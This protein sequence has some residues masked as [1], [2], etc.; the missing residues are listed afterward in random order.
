MRLAR[1]ASLCV[2]ILVVAGLRAGGGEKR[3]RREAEIAMSGS[4]RYPSWTI[5][6]YGVTPEKA[7]EVALNK[8][9]DQ[10]RHYLAHLD[11]PVQ[12]RP[13]GK[14]ID[15]NLVKTRTAPKQVASDD[16][17]LDKAFERTLQIEVGPKQYR[18]IVE[19]DRQE[20]MEQRQL[21]LARILAG[22]VALLVAAVGYLRL[23][24]ATKGY[25]TLWLRLAALGLVGAVGA[26]LVLA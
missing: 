19:Y 20:C 2:L 10:V 9:S 22:V 23:D 24:E 15:E 26:A 4:A 3:P 12:W 13:D 18:E 17:L 1:F 7:E 11:P 6:A 21:L 8:A 16:P 25:Y 5:T 14:W